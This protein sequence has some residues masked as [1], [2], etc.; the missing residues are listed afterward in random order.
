VRVKGVN[1]M[2]T[3]SAHTIF[4]PECGCQI[5]LGDQRN[6]YGRVFINNKRM[7][8]HRASWQLTYGEL[9]K[10]MCVLHKCD[11]GLCVNPAHLFL[12]TRKDNMIDMDNKNRRKAGVGERHRKAKLTN[13]QVLKIRAS[14]KTPNQLAEEF[15]MH[16]STIRMIKKHLIWRHL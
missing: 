4:I 7:L 3:F 14:G 1:S 5:W 2:A 10:N 16:P 13:A 11:V 6:G 12:G 9:P 15:G 8:A